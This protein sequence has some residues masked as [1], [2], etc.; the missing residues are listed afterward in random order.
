MCAKKVVKSRQFGPAIENMRQG[1][2]QQEDFPWAPA[3]VACDGGIMH[4]F[5][6]PNIGIMVLDWRLKYPPLLL[7]NN[8]G[9]EKMRRTEKENT[10]C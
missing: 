8:A 4:S 7:M 6:N 1:H 3:K 5:R 2:T 9:M 10:C